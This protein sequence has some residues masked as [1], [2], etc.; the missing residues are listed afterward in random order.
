MSHYKILSIP[1]AKI[2]ILGLTW[3]QMTPLTSAS[4]QG[5]IC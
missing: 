2:I 3:E 5:F 4:I 1:E